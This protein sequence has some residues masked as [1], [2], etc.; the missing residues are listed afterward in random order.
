[1]G[2]PADR[3]NEDFWRGILDG[4]NPVYAATRRRMK[5]LPGSPR[6]RMCA[7]PF[8][9]PGSWIVRLQGRHRWEKNPDFCNLCFKVLSTYHGG[10]ELEGSFL[11]ADVRG[12][13]ALA[14]TMTPTAFRQL[15]DRFYRTA[16]SVLVEHDGIVDKFVGDEAIGIFIPATAGAAH[17]ERAID[18]GRALLAATG[19]G[20]ASGPWLPVGIGVASGTAFIGSIGTGGPT[21]ETLSA[22]GDV[23]NVTARLASSAAAGEIL[24]NERAAELSGLGTARL[25]RRTLDLKGKSSATTVFVLTTTAV[26]PPGPEDR[27]HPPASG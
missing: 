2:S 6:C 5:R 3:Q 7:A 13:T 9:P 27:V 14:E 1:M 11:F 16:A 17:A 24:V 19:H 4:T 25:E 22:L 18:A 20:A 12:S 26:P 23:V 8:G 10:A 21:S 15:L